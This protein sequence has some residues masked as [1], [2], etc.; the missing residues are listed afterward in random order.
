M[1]AVKL[2]LNF[3]PVMIFPAGAIQQ[4]QWDNLPAGWD[5]NLT[6]WLVRLP[7]LVHVGPFTGM[8]E[9]AYGQNLAGDTTFDVNMC[10]GESAW[11][12]FFRNKT[13]QILNSNT[14][15]YWGDIAVTFGMFTPH[16]YAGQDIS[17]PDSGVY[18]YGEKYN[19]RTL[20]GINCY[21]KLSKNFT[22]IPEIYASDLGYACGF[23]N[24]YYPAPYNQKV[25][26]GQ[27]VV[28]GLEFKF[29]F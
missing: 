1:L 27:D 19:T 3:G 5:K 8:F 24:P 16:I 13:G 25:G 10:Q 9:A 15:A 20:Y 18:Q 17:I 11:G 23:P 12:G 6:T 28:G 22:I 14:F 4:V 26:I 29:Q 7:V 21:I 2:D